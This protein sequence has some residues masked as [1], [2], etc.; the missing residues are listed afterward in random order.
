[1]QPV[2]VQAIPL[3]SVLAALGLLVVLGAVPFMLF[4][5][6]GACKC[7]A[8]LGASW[9]FVVVFLSTSVMWIASLVRLPAW[10]TRTA[11]ATGYLGIAGALA[12][13]LVRAV[14]DAAQI[15]A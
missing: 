13:G 7:D 10:A 6:D 15:I 14:S 8:P 12:F 9:S 3:Y 5:G 2:H 1:M 11:T 4:D